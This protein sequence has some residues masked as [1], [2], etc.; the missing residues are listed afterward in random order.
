M[1]RN[2]EVMKHLEV[3][4]KIELCQLNQAIQTGFIF[5][6]LNSRQKKQLLIHKPYQIFDCRFLESHKFPC[7][8]PEQTRVIIF[9]SNLLCLFNHVRLNGNLSL[10]RK[11][12]QETVLP[13]CLLLWY[14]IKSI[15][16]KNINCT[17]SPLTKK[18][19]I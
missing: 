1:H 9:S 2:N 14:Q 11:F 15:H 5:S 17:F 12:H 10:F 3:Q 19:T 8:Y 18:N 4:L 16:Y 6:C 7:F 13:T